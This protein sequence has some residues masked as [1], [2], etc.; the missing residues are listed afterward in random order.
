MNPEKLLVAL[1]KYGVRFVIVGG[2]AMVLRGSAYLTDDLDIVYSRD[3][4][5]LDRLVAALRGLK[6]QLRTSGG[7]V[8][9]RFDAR[10]I[11]NGLNF[12]L[13]TTDGNIDLLGEIAGLGG[14]PTVKKHAQKIKLGN[15]E[16][17]VLSIDGL[18]GSKEAAGR[19]KDLLVIPELKALK[20]LHDNV[21]LP[22]S[23][24][25]RAHHPT[26]PRDKR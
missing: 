13:T 19:P 20:E 2:V 14:Y 18:I 17:D 16:F 1:D 11:K 7:D 23:D 25:K 3:A 24:T 21:E 9:F 15:R 10:T 26:R 4:R 8:A 12:A 5:N 6:P 22:K